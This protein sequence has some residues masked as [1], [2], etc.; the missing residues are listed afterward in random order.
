MSYTMVSMPSS[1]VAEFEAANAG[2]E[3]DG[4]IAACD[5]ACR[6]TA[7]SSSW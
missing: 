7:A 6:T 5:W 3:V 1:Q 2:G 4:T